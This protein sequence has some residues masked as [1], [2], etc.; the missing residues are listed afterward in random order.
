MTY[1]CEHEP[2]HLEHLEDEEGTEER[3][4]CEPECVVK[5]LSDYPTVADLDR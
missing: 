3:Y 5:P 4:D 1:V 2:Q